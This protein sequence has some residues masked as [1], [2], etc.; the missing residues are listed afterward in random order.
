[1]R[2]FIVA[3]LRAHHEM[4]DDVL[5]P[6]IAA[7]APAAADGLTGTPAGVRQA[8]REQSLATIGKLSVA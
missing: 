7:V 5:W 2:D 1:V 4:E 6:V 3:Q 8:M